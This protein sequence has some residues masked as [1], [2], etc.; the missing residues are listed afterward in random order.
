MPLFV[1]VGLGPLRYVRRIAGRG[2]PKPVVR[3]DKMLAVEQRLAAAEVRIRASSAELRAN[4]DPFRAK[5][6]AVVM[7]V[8]LVLLVLIFSLVLFG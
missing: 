4:R 6:N 3:A 8:S 7:A 1:N 5:V 2:D